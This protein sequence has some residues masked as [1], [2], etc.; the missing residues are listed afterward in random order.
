MAN[1][2]RPMGFTPT[3]MLDGSEIPVKEYP[4]DSGNGTNLFIGDPVEIAAAGSVQKVATSGTNPTR[5]IGV[6][7]GV[8]DSNGVPGAHPNSTVSTKYLP[9]STAGIVSVALALPNALFRIQADTGTDLTSSNLFNQADFVIATGD[10]TTAR[11]KYELD[12][13]G[14]GAAQAQCSVEDK[15][16]EPDN[17]WGEH[18][19]LLVRFNESHYNG[20]IAGI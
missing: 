10:T 11:S 18:A 20:G 6:I 12:S 17:A 14:L 7:T 2:D 15:V 4:V 19:D 3:T 8:K 1:R 5:V 16:D 9:L 13:S